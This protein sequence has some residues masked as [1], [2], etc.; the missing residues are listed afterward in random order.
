MQ[1]IQQSKVRRCHCLFCCKNFYFFGRGVG[2]KEYSWNVFEKNI[3]IPYI[4]LFTC[5]SLH[6]CQEIAKRNFDKVGITR[7]ICCEYYES[8]GRHLHRQPGPEKRTVT[9]I[10]KN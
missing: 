7:Y 3:Q 1:K 5:N 8:K 9:C 2:C 4:R 6:K 10:E